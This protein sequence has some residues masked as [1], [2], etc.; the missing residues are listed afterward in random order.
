MA[1]PIDFNNSIQQSQTI[2]SNFED[3][4]QDPSSSWIFI[5]PDTYANEQVNQMLDYL[6]NSRS[7]SLNLDKSLATL[8]YG[9][10]EST[11]SFFKTVLD[12][13]P[14]ITKD[15]I[16][17]R[18]FIIDWYS[19]HKT[20]ITKSRKSTD[21][22]L[23]RS[24]E[25][26]ELIKGFGFPYPRF[27]TGKSNKISFLLN[28]INLYKRKGTSYSLYYILKLYGLT[29]IIISECWLKHDKNKKDPLYV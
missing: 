5:N 24:D 6:I 19:A 10:K 4:V 18:R 21:L 12:Q 1:D 15:H 13:P 17:I 27:I 29:D 23:L 16:R 3:I 11:K 26:N 25:I 20:L 9:E 7:A 22:Q 14:H 2:S 8:A 28:L